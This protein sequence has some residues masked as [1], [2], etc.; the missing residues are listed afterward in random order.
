ME[1]FVAHSDSAQPIVP[2]AL[3]RLDLIRVPTLVLVG[4][5]DVEH[6]HLVADTLAGK[7]RRSDK[8]VLHGVGHMAS[9]ENADQFNRIVG[10]FRF[11]G[12]GGE[13]Q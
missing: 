12:K 2:P 8:V 11:P 4:E 7:M 5:Y 10:D 1:R 9:M 3:E 6:F 13:C